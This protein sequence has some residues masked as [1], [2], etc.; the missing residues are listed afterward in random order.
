MDECKPL[1]SGAGS[2]VYSGP[3]ASAQ[4]HF[5]SMAFVSRK[6]EGVN[7]ADYMLD[8]VL[9][10]SDDVVQRMIDN[11]AGSGAAS[12]T[13]DIVLSLRQRAQMEL[14]WG[15]IEG[16]GHGGAASLG[17]RSKYKASFARQVRTLW[18]RL[19]RSVR[20]HPFLFM[21][22][23]VATA[24]AALSIGAIFY[25]AGRDTGGIQN[26]MG[27]LFFMLLYLSLMVGTCECTI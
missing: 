20:R 25:D 11:F 15:Q 21:L 22:H 5:A 23:F 18:M 10:S 1:L 26:R 6:P 17:I 27:G 14:P 24:F 3:S 4:E 2:V 8:T 9:R 12:Q 16:S 7:V 19:F 13:A